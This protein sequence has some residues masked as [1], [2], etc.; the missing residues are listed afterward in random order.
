MRS[1]IA[2][3][4]QHD[5]LPFQ[6][7]AGKAA[8]RQ[9]IQP[10]TQNRPRRSLRRAQR[11]GAE[12]AVG[13]PGSQLGFVHSRT[14]PMVIGDR[15]GRHR[16]HFIISTLHRAWKY[17][18]GWCRTAPVR[19][20]LSVAR[21]QPIATGSSVRSAPF[22]GMAVRRRPGRSQRS[23]TREGGLDATDRCLLR[24]PSAAVCI[25]F[26]SS[27]LRLLRTCTKGDFGQGRAQLDIVQSG[28]QVGANIRE[29]TRR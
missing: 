2:R 16:R 9:A 20:H 24:R 29:R 23:F 19:G 18:D 15:I 28:E 6:G 12:E 11:G 7:K 27:F 22:C 17:S 25:A 14:C 8:R 13:T 1:R 10:L 26:A 3:E 4:V 5:L 21:A